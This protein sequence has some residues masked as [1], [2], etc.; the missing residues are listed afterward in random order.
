MKSDL[1]V[2]FPPRS[3]LFRPSELAFVRLTPLKTVS[4][5]P[6]AT[7]TLQ[8]S[9]SDILLPQY[10]FF[11]CLISRRSLLLGKTLYDL[12]EEKNNNTE[13]SQSSA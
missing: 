9:D 2:V 11:I 4:H 10:C 1:C 7:P 12:L 13:L 5:K 3:L 8:K 6:E